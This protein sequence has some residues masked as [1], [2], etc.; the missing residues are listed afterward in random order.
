LVP[1]ELEELEEQA[2][3]QLQLEMAELLGQPG[4]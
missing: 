4:L 1:V 3:Q 2:Q